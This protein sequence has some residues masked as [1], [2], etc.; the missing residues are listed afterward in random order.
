MPR[1]DTP[2]PIAASID[3]AMGRVRVQASDRIDTVVEVRPRNEDSDL[4]VQAVA[5]AEVEYSAGRLRVHV[6]RSWLRTTFGTPPGVE[7]DIEL[8]EGSELDASGW[9]DYV[10]E[11]RLGPVEIQRAIGDVRIE[12]TGRLRVR[13]STGD[14]RVGRADG[15]TDLRTAAGTIRV[16]TIDGSGQIKSSSGELSVGEA[17][18]NLR[19]KTASGDITVEHAWAS[20][21]AKTAAGAIRILEVGGG[22]VDLQTGWGEL[23]IGVP[24]DVA[25]WL[26]LSSKSG[27]VR[28]ELDAADTPADTDKTV[29]VHARTSYGDILVRRP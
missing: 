12:R 11:G 28:S 2:E 8:P 18:G 25:A 16:G 4:D 19:L 13:S 3:L 23:E 22:T 6:P 17:T 9:A 1:F 21:D 15:P 10:I 27:P 7:I 29:E 20:V 24:E 5:Q 26:D 14:I